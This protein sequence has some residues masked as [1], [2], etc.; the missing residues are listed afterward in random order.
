MLFYMKLR[1]KKLRQILSANLHSSQDTESD[2]RRKDGLNKFLRS[3]N[4]ALVLCATPS[5][6]LIYIGSILPISHHSI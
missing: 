4:G 1:Q 2:G 3:V 5:G 6:S